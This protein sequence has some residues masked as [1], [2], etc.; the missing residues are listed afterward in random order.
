[1][2]SAPSAGSIFET[3][4]VDEARGP[5]P[6]GLYGDAGP[7]DWPPGVCGGGMRLE[8]LD[9]GDGDEGRRGAWLRGVC[10]N[11]GLGALDLCPVMELEALDL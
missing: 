3:R 8:S 4:Y 10:G 2:S 1:M 5:Q 9:L 6:R 7:L 11:T